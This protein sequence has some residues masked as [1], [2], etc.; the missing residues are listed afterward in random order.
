MQSHLKETILLAITESKQITDLLLLMYGRAG[1]KGR[2]IEL[3]RL[4]RHFLEECEKIKKI[5]NSS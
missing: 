5:T 1:V 2:A 3:E 4:A